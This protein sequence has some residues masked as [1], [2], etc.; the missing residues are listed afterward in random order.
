MFNIFAAT[1]V[2]IKAKLYLLR[3]VN[4]LKYLHPISLKGRY[5]LIK[6]F[7]NFR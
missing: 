2:D 5:K 7:N 4:I 6:R 3:S 1:N